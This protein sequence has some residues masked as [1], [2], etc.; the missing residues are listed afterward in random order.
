MIDAMKI[1][2]VNFSTDIRKNLHIAQRNPCIIHLNLLVWGRDRRGRI[3]QI[4]EMANFQLK[5]F[6]IS[7]IKHNMKQSFY[8]QIFESFNS[9][10]QCNLFENWHEWC[11]SIRK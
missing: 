5:C 10:G 3:L 1:E 6:R 11:L 7:N 8:N 9:S 4:S 2:K